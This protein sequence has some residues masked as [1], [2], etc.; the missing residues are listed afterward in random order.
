MTTRRRLPQDVGLA[1]RR[2]GRRVHGRRR[3]RRCAQATAQARRPV[4]RSRLPAARLVD[5][6]PPGQHRDVLRRQDRSRPGHRHGLPPDHVRRTRHRL[7]QD[8][9]RHGQ[10][11]RHRRPG[12]LRRLGR[13]RRADGWPM[14]R[15][16][17]EARRV[18]LEMAST[19]LGVPVAALTVRDGV[20]SVTADPVEAASPMASSIGGKRFNV[21]LTGE[22]INDHHG[23]GAAQARA[24]AR[25][26]SASRCSATT[27][28]AKVDGSLK[29]AVDVKLPGMVHARNVKPPVAGA[30]LVSIDES[31]RP[32]PARLRPG[33]AARAT[34]SP[35]SASA[36]SRPSA[37]RGS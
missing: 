36:K 7:R 5:R 14:R 1:R 8:Q 37:R 27:S 26:S 28:R 4:S 17:A 32:R 10:H 18:L 3:S 29:W 12:R 23:R 35:W 11:R 2:R 9:L 24:G 33:R 13:P 25:R 15:V 20:I 21:T 22:N 34:T 16:A 30:T 31:L 19:R 6:H